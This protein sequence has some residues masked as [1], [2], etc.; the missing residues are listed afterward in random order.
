VVSTICVVLV[1]GDDSDDDGDGVEEDSGVEVLCDGVEL[2]D[3]CCEVLGGVD[4]A[5]DELSEELPVGVEEVEG[6]EDEGLLEVGNKAF[7]TSATCTGGED[8][9]AF[10]TTSSR[11]QKGPSNQLACA[12]AK[13]TT[14]AESTRK[15]CGRGSMVMDGNDR[16]AVAGVGVVD[17]EEWDGPRSYLKRPPLCVC[18]R[19]WSESA[20]VV[21]RERE[22]TQ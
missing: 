3:L 17:D 5:L 14:S 18:D 11:P 16:I 4:E 10:L 21:C 13:K 19:R 6:A 8:T 20:G 12:K 15:N 2:E 1:G 9:A 22:A 7:E